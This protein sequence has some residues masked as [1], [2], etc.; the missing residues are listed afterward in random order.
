MEVM[1]AGGNGKCVVTGG[2]TGGLY[3]TSVIDINVIDINVILV[4]MISLECFRENHEYEK[5][6]K[7]TS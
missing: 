7:I 4:R 1:R 3:T 5:L 6:K 2:C